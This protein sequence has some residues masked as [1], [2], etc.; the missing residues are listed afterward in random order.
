MAGGMYFIAFAQIPPMGG[1]GSGG[2]DY[3]P[4][5]N[6]YPPPA[7]GG[8]G[9]GDGGGESEDGGGNSGGG[10]T[11]DDWSD[12]GEAD[13]FRDA[14]R[15]KRQK[16]KKPYYGPTGFG[17]PRRVKK[18]LFTGNPLGN[19][20]RISGNTTDPVAQG[21]L[22]G[23]GSLLRILIGLYTGSVYAQ[24]DSAISHW[25]ALFYSEGDAQRSELA[26]NT[27]Y[28]E[29]TAT[30]MDGAPHKI[31][32]LMASKA[33]F[34]IYESDS[35]QG[36]FFMV[37][38]GTM[39]DALPVAH[40]TISIPRGA[41]IPTETILKLL[42][43]SGIAV[44]DFFVSVAHAL[45]AKEKETE[46]YLKK[47]KANILTYRKIP[48][49]M[50]KIEE[51]FAR[52]NFDDPNFD[53]Y[54]VE[55]E[56]QALVDAYEKKQNELDYLALQLRRAAPFVRGGDW[57]SMG[58]SAAYTLMDAGI[59]MVPATLIGA[60][61]GPFDFYTVQTVNKKE[62]VIGGTCTGKN[63]SATGEEVVCITRKVS[64][65]QAKAISAANDA[66][67]K[68]ITE[69]HDELGNIE[70]ALFELTEQ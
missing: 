30:D 28:Q 11:F 42:T 55:D 45:T 38:M 21:T 69:A 2:G 65:A 52:Y 15:Q 8:D 1:G 18:I 47:T 39:P 10:D 57:L 40:G 16:P 67:T 12:E 53:Y 14:V 64:A 37:D 32:L 46:A 34:G 41:G 6:N 23:R 29:E 9:D 59:D 50:R 44:R 36:S 35:L 3:T 31:G 54:A 25:I 27:I 26:S 49:V 56:V 62:I 20:W 24:F 17:D 60:Y 61:N 68:R 19:N 66:Y 63:D 58:G 13:E 51:E 43:A 7:G 70:S 33:L 22:T 5:G 48:P 4:P